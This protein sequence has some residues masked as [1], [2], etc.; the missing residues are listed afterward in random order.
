VVSSIKNNLSIIIRIVNKLYRNFYRDPRRAKIASIILH[1]APSPNP[2]PDTLFSVHSLIRKKDLIMSIWSAKSLNLACN[3]ALCWF[4]HDDGSLT[5]DDYKFLSYHFPGCTI[6]K[7]S[8]TD[9][10]LAPLRSQ[11]PLTL[12]MRDKYV[13]MLK[14]VDLAVFSEKQLIL[15]VDSDILF[16]DKPVQIISQLSDKKC[17][18]FFN[19]DIQSSYLYTTVKLKEY[20][21]IQV[22]E[23][24]NAGLSILHKDTIQLETIETLLQQIPLTPNLIFHRIEQTLITLLS[25]ISHYGIAYLDMEYDVSL[26]K[27][28]N[29]AVCKHYVGAIRHQFELE[30]I[31]YL[32]H[33]LSFIERWNSFTTNR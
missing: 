24:I 29:N 22:P 14:L 19:K 18:N 17:S 20:T 11:F 26:K 2:V 7:R 8:V 31:Q 25:S 23:K 6:L 9:E 1:T 28:I 16:F 21:G 27:S 13:M 4:F 5:E 30:G 15:Y 33:E 10:K 12:S 3:Q 32:L